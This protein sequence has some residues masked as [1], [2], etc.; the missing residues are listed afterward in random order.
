MKVKELVVR[1]VLVAS[2]LCQSISVPTPIMASEVVT[3]STETIE[4]TESAE[5]TDSQ[6]DTQSTE[7]SEIS[8]T[9][10]VAESPQAEESTESI[11]SSTLVDETDSSKEGNTDSA[12]NTPTPVVEGTE[13]IEDS[14]EEVDESFG[15]FAGVDDIDSA[16]GV[17]STEEDSSA[18]TEDT[19]LPPTMLD[20]GIAL[21][22]A[23]TAASRT[24]YLHFN[25][26]DYVGRVQK[27]Q[28]A[29]NASNS[30]RPMT[31][32]DE[33]N[34]SAGD[35]SGAYRIPSYFTYNGNIG[36]L[37]GKDSTVSG[38]ALGIRRKG[39]TFT[40]WYT[41]KTGGTQFWNANG[42]LVAT[43]QSVGG[44]T[45]SSGGKYKWTNDV[46]TTVWAHYA[47]NDLKL[48]F[49]G[50]DSYPS[51]SDYNN[52]S[53][54]GTYNGEDAHTLFGAEDKGNNT[55]LYKGYNTYKES[56]AGVFGKGSVTK[57]GY[58]LNGWYTSSSGGTKTYNSNGAR[59]DG[60]STFTGS[61]TTEE[62]WARFT[63]NN[64]TVYFDRNGG[65]GVST[66][67]KTVTY[68]S[69]YGDLASAWC[70]GYDFVGWYTERTGGT[71][72]TSST[73]YKIAGNST[74]YA[75]W[76]PSKYTLYF[77]GNGGTA[78]KSSKEVTYRS[79]YGD[80]GSASR[81]GYT[82]NGWY[83]AASGGTQ[84]SS[85]DTY[86]TAGD[87]TLYAHWTANTYTVAFHGNGGTPEYN[88]KNV[89]Y[90][91]NYGSLPNASRTGYTF[92]GWYTSADGGDHITSDTVYK[93]AGNTDLYAHWTPNKYTLYFDGNT[94]TA[95]YG[96]KTVTYDSAY[97]D[98][99]TASKTHY[100][101]D[102]WF[103]ARSGGSQVTSSTI[104][105]TA[106][107]STVYAHYHL[108]ECVTRHD[109]QGGS[110]VSDRTDSIFGKYG[111]L[112][113]PTR[114]GWDFLGWYTQ[115]NGK[116]D[117]V[118]GDTDVPDV[119]YTTIYANWQVHTSTVEIKAEVNQSSVVYAKGNPVMVIQ[120]D[121]TDVSGEKHTYVTTVEWTAI[122][123]NEQTVTVDI[124]SG[125]Y[126]A[127]VLA[128]NDYSN[129]D[130]QDIDTSQGNNVSVKFTRS[131]NDYSKYTG[132]DLSI[133]KLK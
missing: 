94:G 68:D 106:D 96:S 74:L 81:T 15:G 16:Y 17:D 32:V 49:D 86:T 82:F 62:Y 22:S 127:T 110:S 35:N 11:E 79:S 69:T 108:I 101:F 2:L 78:T 104:Y 26:C 117:R 18:Y 98:L 41:G 61:G 73:T 70:T 87:S 29:W 72:V 12:V 105:K 128:E 116:G 131:E 1:G 8:E 83:T 27:W 50:A 90:D 31:G 25:N 129:V 48:H 123:P 60:K 37:W 84:K 30:S 75:H 109:S 59:C 56:Y 118:T 113:T 9:K 51:A 77:N 122:S 115:P 120:L 132:N 36:G 111:S 97:G 33:H 7:S 103:T 42:T 6:V 4:S 24:I 19:E 126:K 88:S 114:P 34:N 44:A 40:G 119:E 3:E 23:G 99:A 45:W 46:G 66:G 52:A 85:S 55:I 76:T 67:S 65:D 133:T 71:R 21:Y 58:T 47:R 92:N 95:S 112:A 54:S 91:S 125:N 13:S 53:I 20:Y 43:N 38:G 64:Y 102:G 63:P 14:S 130:A 28:Q 10:E 124:K 5:E 121:G 93:T 57:T 89:S 39:H 80:L 107:N 100:A